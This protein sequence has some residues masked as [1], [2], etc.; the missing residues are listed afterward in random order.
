MRASPRRAEHERLALQG[1]EASPDLR[2]KLQGPDTIYGIFFLPVI[3]QF[4]ADLGL[5]SSCLYI[6]LYTSI[7]IYTHVNTCIGMSTH[8]PICMYIHMCIHMLY[9][10]LCTCL[11]I[12]LCTCLCTCS[13]T[14][15]HFCTHV[16]AHVYIYMSIDAWASAHKN[17]LVFG[18][19]LQNQLSFF[20]SFFLACRFAVR[21]NS[22]QNWTERNN[23]Y[24]LC[25]MAISVWLSKPLD[26]TF[27]SE[28]DTPLVGQSYKNLV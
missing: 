9:A 16:C 2:R 7:R 21:Y 22:H 19:A 5:V 13:Y 25:Q 8:M 23:G 24:W 3:L 10:F 15:P 4:A 11:C 26:R 1:P 17:C 14:F 20:F 27:R 6:C 28:L 18:I 12:C